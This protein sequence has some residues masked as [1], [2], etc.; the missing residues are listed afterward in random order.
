MKYLIAGA[1][2]FLAALNCN[3]YEQPNNPDRFISAGVNYGMGSGDGSIDNTNNPNTP[4]ALSYTDQREVENRGVG[5][6][7]RIPTSRSMTWTLSY[8][9][10]NTELKLHGDQSAIEQT[11]KFSVNTYNIGLRYYFNK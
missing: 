9:R 11:E 6:D 2:L 10:T 5:L 7:L 3:A 8:L 1:V 4:F